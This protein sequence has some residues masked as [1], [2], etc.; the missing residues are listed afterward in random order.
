MFVPQGRPFLQSAYKALQL[1]Q[2]IM[3]VLS[4]RYR[5]ARKIASRPE[6]TFERFFYTPAVE[7]GSTTLRELALM[8]EGVAF[9]AMEA[10]PGAE[11]R[12]VAWAMLDAAGARMVAPDW[13]DDPA[14]THRKSG[15]RRGLDPALDQARQSST[16]GMEISG[17]EL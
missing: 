5:G 3:P 10:R 14:A 16:P 15:G 2:C 9:C 11:G 1:S 13:K 6:P 12:S 4:Q 17:V 8:R 7:E